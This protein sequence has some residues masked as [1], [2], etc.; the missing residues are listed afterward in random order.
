MVTHPSRSGRPS[1]AAQASAFIQS[2]ISEGDAQVW[3]PGPDL[4]DQLMQLAVE[5]KIAGPRIFD[6]EIALTAFENGAREIWTH[7]RNF[8]A[9]PGLRVVDP[10]RR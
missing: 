10:L 7:D 3:L 4:V 8:V 1:T 5:L 6:L 2:L 9:I